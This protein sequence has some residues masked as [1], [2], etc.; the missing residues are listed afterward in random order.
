[1]KIIREKRNTGCYIIDDDEAPAACEA[2]DPTVSIHVLT[3]IEPV[4]EGTVLAV[5]CQAKHVLGVSPTER[6]A[7]GGY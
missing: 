4:L 7:I 2:S 1:M 6:R 3:R 5:R